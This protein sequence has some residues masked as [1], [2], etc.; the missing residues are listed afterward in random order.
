MALALRAG[1]SPDALE[2]LVGSIIT[3]LSVSLPVAARLHRGGELER[4]VLLLDPD[5]DPD[6]RNRAL[7]EAL[8]LVTIGPAAAPSAQKVQRRHLR[9]VS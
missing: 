2:Q 4:P 6:D 7:I 1:S 5:A 8:A 3:I 9:A